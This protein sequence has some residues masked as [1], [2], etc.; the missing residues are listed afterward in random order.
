VLSYFTP[1]PKRRAMYKK[2]LE[3][4]KFK[5]RYAF[6]LSGKNATTV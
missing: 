1:Q 4:K 6:P 3:V 2:G 5:K